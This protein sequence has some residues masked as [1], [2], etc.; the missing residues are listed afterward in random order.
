MHRLPVQSVLGAGSHVR[1]HANKLSIF[2]QSC[3]L[4]TE[5]AMCSNTH[6]HGVIVMRASLI[7]LLQEK[8]IHDFLARMVTDF[9]S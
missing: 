4:P 6:G 3:Q 5:F 2:P 9:S 8:K 1:I 7:F